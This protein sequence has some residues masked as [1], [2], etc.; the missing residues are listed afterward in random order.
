MPGV[1]WSSQATRGWCCAVSTELFVR[2]LVIGFAV[3][4]ALLIGA[5]RVGAIA[6]GIAGQGR[7]T[8]RTLSV[9]TISPC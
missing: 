2:G 6:L 1:S 4:F 8:P 5:F 3:A 7:P 9:G